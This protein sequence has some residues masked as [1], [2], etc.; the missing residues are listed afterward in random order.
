MKKEEYFASSDPS[1]GVGK[2]ALF[3]PVDYLITLANKAPGFEHALAIEL[4]TRS[5]VFAFPILQLLGQAKQFRGWRDSHLSCASQHFQAP[6][7]LCRES[8]SGSESSWGSSQASC[9]CSGTKSVLGFR[10]GFVR[11]TFIPPDVGRSRFRL[12]R[13]E[14]NHSLAAHITGEFLANAGCS[15]RRSSHR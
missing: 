14:T 12:A 4:S 5:I 2:T 7:R 6:A 15:R 8:S 10:C 13:E 3:Q 9:F 11:C 1:D